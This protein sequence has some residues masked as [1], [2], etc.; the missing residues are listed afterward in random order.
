MD[1]LEKLLNKVSYKFP[2]GYLDINNKNDVMLLEKLLKKIGIDLQEEKNRDKDYDS[3]IINL[4]KSISDEDVKKKVLTYLKKK[5]TAED[6]ETYK[7][8]ESILSKKGL[9]PSLVELIFLYATASYQEDKLLEYVKSPTLEWTN[10]D[11]N[12]KTQIKKAGFTDSFIEKTFT[13][14][15]TE[16]GKGVGFGEVPLVLFFDGE[17]VKT[18]DV[19]IGSQLIEVKGNGGRFSSGKGK[20]REGNI[21]SVYEKFKE[22]Y[23]NAT[24]QTNLSEY[25]NDI[26]TKYP[27][28]EKEINK[29]LL[30]IYPG[31]ENYI[32]TKNSTNKDLLKKYVANYVDS[33]PPQIY[34]LISNSGEYKLY[35]GEKL[36]ETAGETNE[37]GIKFYGNI[38]PS[39]A[40]PQLKLT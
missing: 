11:G 16:G 8:L 14:K 2:K 36:I 28:S 37:E 12:L 4:L 1:I 15:P 6:N 29:S 38:T 32:I 21:T 13:I 18:G 24:Y 33:Q 35:T 20:G 40:Y 17:K 31:T 9:S 22:Q 34:M 10:V 27:E 26:L 5:D 19:K 23:K 39:S 7:E 3:E 25:V 30:E